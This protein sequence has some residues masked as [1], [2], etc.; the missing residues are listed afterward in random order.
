MQ[1][2]PSCNAATARGEAARRGGA[3]GPGSR[4]ALLGERYQWRWPQ[5]SEDEQRLFTEVSGR[6]KHWYKQLRDRFQKQWGPT[7]PRPLPPC[8]APKGRA[9]PEA[10][11]HVWSYADALP[12]RYRRLWDE[13]RLT[14]RCREIAERAR[15]SLRA[16][17]TRDPQQY[18]DD[19]VRRQCGPEAQRLDGAM[20]ADRRQWS[21]HWTALE[22]HD[23]LQQ[24]VQLE[25][26]QLR[27]SS[28]AIGREAE[29]AGAGPRRHEEAG[30]GQGQR[31]EP[32][33]VGS[34]PR[35][36]G[37]VPLSRSGGSRSRLWA[38]LPFPHK[39]FRPAK[40]RRGECS[41]GNERTAP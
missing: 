15:G 13:R 41:K 31:Q 12:E 33:A 2:P 1:G 16:R 34:S 7:D 40:P 20:R 19:A 23:K 21:G 37:T 35:V 25:R 11:R 17:F 10:P 4:R 27:R 36:R 6:A 8:L 28:P 14:E 24:Q 38:V 29:L 22:R 9:A 30:P 32:L 39:E 18:A 5:A 26:E 3:A